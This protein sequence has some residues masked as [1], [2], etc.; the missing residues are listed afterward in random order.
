MREGRL[1]WVSYL[2]VVGAGFSLGT[3]I[4]TKGDRDGGGGGDREGRG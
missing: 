1:R 3:V 4:N 2:E